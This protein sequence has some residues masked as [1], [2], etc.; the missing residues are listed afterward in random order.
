ML[1]AAPVSGSIANTCFYGKNGVICWRTML[2]SMDA[3]FLFCQQIRAASF[4]VLLLLG[5]ASV[6]VLVLVLIF[7]SNIGVV[8]YFMFL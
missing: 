3:G 4:L 8:L 2:R 1:Y 7:F 6:Y 5:C